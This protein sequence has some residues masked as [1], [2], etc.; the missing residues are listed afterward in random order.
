VWPT[1]CTASPPTDSGRFTILRLPEAM[2]PRPGHCPPVR[3][4]AFELKWKPLASRMAR[5]LAEVV[6]E[7]P[8]A[9]DSPHYAR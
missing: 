1:R 6:H 3:G 4:G 8:L 9:A 7:G 2:L 5:A